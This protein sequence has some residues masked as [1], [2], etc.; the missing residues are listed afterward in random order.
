[1]LRLQGT[2]IPEEGLSVSASASASDKNPMDRGVQDAYRCRPSRAGAELH[3]SSAKP[4]TSADA[5]QI[6]AH[7]TAART[8]R[9]YHTFSGA[10]N[11]QDCCC[12]QALMALDQSCCG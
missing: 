11:R 4:I 1:M 8:D 10:H 3:A 7:G 2:S 9:Q 5:G 6:L 12:R